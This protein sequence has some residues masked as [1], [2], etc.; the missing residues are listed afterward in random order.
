[1]QKTV[2]VNIGER[3]YRI[4]IEPGLLARTADH[5]RAL[6]PPPAQIALMSSKTVALYYRQTVEHA[7]RD[8]GYDVLFIPMPTGEEKKNLTAVSA[9][10][11]RMIEASLDRT[12]IVITL[13]GGVVGD[14]GG[15]AAATLYRGIP[16]IQMPTTLLAQVDSSVG[17]KVGVN[18]PLGKNLIGSF[19]QPKAVLIDPEVLNTLDMRERISGFGEVLKYG[20]IRDADLLADCLRHADDLLHLRHMEK[21]A[22]IIRRSLMI[23]AEIVSRDEHESGLRMLLNFGHTV[24]HAIEQALGYGV[25]RH[26][27]GVILGM[28]AALRIS[29]LT[30]GL[31]E[32]TF[33]SLITQLARIPLACELSALDIDKALKAI[34][35]D[36]KIRD[37]RL[38]MV[39]LEEIGKP[40]IADDI[41]TGMIAETLAWLKTG[42][43]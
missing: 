11:D 19:Y 23:K 31:P 39:L 6:I 35:H 40:V 24:G 12:G 13:G 4:T 21:V 1:M 27:E 3:S 42:Y 33:R 34:S 41:S 37:G 30:R 5:V 14:V 43:K 25:C 36:K 7:L 17:G 22:E 26:G 2:D 9:L 8:A 18:H 28:C 15:F 29:M 16:F 10:Y 38:H 32:G 20:F